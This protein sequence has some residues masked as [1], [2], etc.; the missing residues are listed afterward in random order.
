MNWKYRYAYSKENEA[1][2]VVDQLAEDYPANTLKWVKETKWSGPEQ[3][4]IKD[5]DYSNYK[6]WEAHH[7]QNKVK[8]FENKISKGKMKP[9]VLVK[10]PKNKKYIVI[11]GHHRALAYR[12]LNRPLLAWIGKTKSEDGPWDVFHAKQKH[13]NDPDSTKAE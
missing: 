4:E 5:V 2:V 8:K 9:V 6:H 11:D 7:E 1:P 12:N 3:V 13:S 10:T